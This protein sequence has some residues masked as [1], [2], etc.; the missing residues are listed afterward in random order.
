[1][2]L[3]AVM[4]PDVERKNRECRR[5]DSWR[6]YS[7]Q[8]D[9]LALAPRPSRPFL[10]VANFIYYTIHFSSRGSF[11]IGGGCTV[12]LSFV[13]AGTLQPWEGSPRGWW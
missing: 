9:W 3:T 8:S 1:M 13:L 12:S 5:H 10:L 2:G 6:C 7:A 4:I 11:G